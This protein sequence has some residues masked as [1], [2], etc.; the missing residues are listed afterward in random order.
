VRP[1]GASGDGG[2]AHGL[3]QWRGDRW[4]GLQNFA[5]QNGL[6]PNSMDAQLG[7]LDRELKTGYRGAYDRIMGAKNPAEAAGAFGLLYER[8]KGAETGVAA[9][10]DGYGNRVRQA[11]ALFGSGSAHEAGPQAPDPTMAG[12]GAAPMGA[13]ANSGE[14]NGLM[15]QWDQIN[16]AMMS[17]AF[18]N[19]GEAGQNALKQRAE[20]IKTRLGMLGKTEGL[21]ADYREYQLASSDP[22]FAKYMQ[23][24]RGASA[25]GEGAK[26]TE[27]ANARRQLIIDQGG[28]PDDPQSKQFILSGKFPRED[29]TPLTATDK[30]AIL[31]ADDS[32]ASTQSYIKALQEAQKLSH[33]AMG[34][35]GAGAVAKVG[36]VLGNQTSINT[37]E[38]D[39][40][41]TQNALNQLKSTFGA[42]PT[43]GER[44]ILMQMQGGASLPDAVRQ[45]MYGRALEFAQERLTKNQARADELRGG[46]FYKTGGGNSTKP[47]GQPQGQSQ[48]HPMEGRTATNPQTG[49]RMIFRNGNW[50]KY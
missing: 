43:E 44:Q 18:A 31:E 34:F 25:Q 9:N 2:T 10:I 3:A 4:T 12:A 6:D 40:L 30:K 50:A 28:N 46:E 36:S 15:K 37:S 24:K 27:V 29:Q 33:S 26:I 21:P 41:V 13:Q 42:A 7:W 39:A 5:R 48:A 45:R 1:V 20:M 22:N 32:V 8:P 47:A 11:M 38:L 17:P 19:A 16:R 35:P 14:V 23:D 49:E